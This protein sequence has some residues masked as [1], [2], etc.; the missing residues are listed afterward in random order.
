MMRDF[1]VVSL[2]LETSGL[3]FEKHTI[4]SIGCVRL[5]DMQNLYTEVRHK[6]LIVDPAAMKVNGI[7]ITKV[8]DAKR[9]P[10]N[11]L[12]SMLRGW[13]KSDKFYKEGKTY[14]L[15]PMGLNVGSFDM[16]FVHKYLPKSAALFGYRSIDLNTLVFEEA[17]RRDV[18]FKYVKEAAKTLGMTYAHE[19]VPDLGPHNALWDAYSNIGMFNYL[20][21]M[22][23]EKIGEV[24]WEGGKLANV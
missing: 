16:K 5:S 4:L 21:N 9:I 8:D 2:D 15:I 17:I 24:N 12:D 20:T 6:N 11:F 1:D 3:D 14:T 23:A 19:H 18:D 22:K 7:D 13:L 10:I